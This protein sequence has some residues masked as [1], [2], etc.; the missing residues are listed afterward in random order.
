MVLGG[1]RSVEDGPSWYMVV[2]DGKWWYLVIMGLSDAIWRRKINGDIRGVNQ[3]HSQLPS[4][5]DYLQS[6]R[7]YGDF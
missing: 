2:L 3:L 6:I 7:V 5:G 4:K 1:T